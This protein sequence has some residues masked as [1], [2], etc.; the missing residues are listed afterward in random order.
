MAVVSLKARAADTFTESSDTALASHSAEIGGQNWIPTAGQ[1]WSVKGGLGRVV[2]TDANNYGSSTLTT[3][4]LW[5]GWNMVYGGQYGGTSSAGCG[6]TVRHIYSGSNWYQTWYLAYMVQGASNTF[7]QIRLYRIS[8]G[9][10]TQLT[11]VSKSVT[12]PAYCKLQ[13]SGSSPTSLSASMW[14]TTEPNTWDTTTTDNTAGN[15]T[16]AEAPIGIY[17]ESS[18]GGTVG[19]YIDEMVAQVNAGA[20]TVRTQAVNRAAVF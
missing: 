18:A 1:G 4:K 8:G 16:T 12:P 17:I 11:T 3:G 13:V 15:Q 19:S 14:A 20:A 9:G 6:P 2:M 10:Y 5:N 7:S